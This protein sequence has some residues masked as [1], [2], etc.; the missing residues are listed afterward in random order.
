MWEALGSVG[1]ERDD[2]VPGGTPGVPELPVFAHL[3]LLV[4][5]QRKKLSK[6]REEV[7]V[8]SYRDRGYLPEA[9]V[10]FLA[11]LGWSPPSG[12]EIFTVDQL[13]AWFQLDQVN[14][15]P[16]FFDTA[17]FTHINGEYIRALPLD[18]FVDACRPWTIGPDTPW[19]SDSF[20]PAVFAALAPRVQER[21]AVLD[22]VPA[23]VDFAFL[24]APD[25]DQAAWQKTVVG[26]P[27]ATDILQGAL[28]AYQ[29]LT[30]DWTLDA[31][32]DATAALADTV[33]RKLGKAQAPIRVAVMGRT[34]GLPLFDSL[35]VL[36]RAETRRRLGV[37]LDR[38]AAAP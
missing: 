30:D 17:K 36:G 19:P 18:D 2:S 4:N 32:K 28:D 29:T 37:A 27:V 9:F 8:E 10:N 22:E 31:L 24:D 6:R 33:G 35:A 26:D 15:S 11:L 20:D 7:A 1:W 5:E 21:V 14:H 16:A 38:L 13:I 34:R 12:E 3:P 25:V 23:M